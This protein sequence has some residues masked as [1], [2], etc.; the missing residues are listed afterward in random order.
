MLGP[1][2]FEGMKHL[3]LRRRLTD[4]MSILLFNLQIIIGLDQIGTII[5]ATVYMYVY[6]EKRK[7]KSSKN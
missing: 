6:V 2:A 1:E 5:I 7:K 3:I 4:K